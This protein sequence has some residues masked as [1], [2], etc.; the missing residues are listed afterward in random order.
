[1][2]D[3]VGLDLD[4][5]FLNHLSSAES[6]QVINGEGVTHEILEDEYV[7][8]VFEWQKHHLRTYHKVAT[9]NVLYDEFPDLELD[10][11]Q[12]TIGDL[13]DRLRERFAR[14]KQKDSIRRIL[15]LQ[16]ESPLDVPAQLIRSGRE[17]ASLTKKKGEMFGSGDFD[18]L[19]HIYNRQV[20][21]GPGASYGWPELDEYFYGMRGLN[22]ILGSPKSGKSWLG[23]NILKENVLAG[24][25]TWL[26]SLE[27]PAHET[28]FRLQCLI[29]DV[30]FWKYLHQSITPE[31]KQLMREASDV[32]DDSGMYRIVKPPAGKRGIDEMVNQA[33]DGGADLIIID[34]LQYV[35]ADDG[36]NL[37]SHNQ[38][39]M[40]WNV[41][42]TAR[43]YSD[44]GPIVYLHQFS[45]AAMNCEGM[46]SMEYAKGSASIE[47]T[48]T[49]ALGLWRDKNSGYTQEFKMGVLCSR[50]HPQRIWDF[51]TEMRDGCRFECLGEA[52]EADES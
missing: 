19:M 24:R 15:H 10:E 23:I 3:V 11:P 39:G 48:A 29:A 51:Y 4:L 30:P 16:E 45:R 2:I 46:P 1:M 44:D 36:I 5:E 49:V 35:E 14:T 6:W 43:D 13:I 17:L 12:T 50:N 32:L 9:A 52:V 18:R 37:G 28:E 20:L 26:F 25:C 21:Q 38:T 47:E 33:R 8:K 27:L 34:Q 40:Y 42:N 7:I 22:A 41:L 31:E